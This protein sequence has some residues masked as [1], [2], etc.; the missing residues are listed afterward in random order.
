MLDKIDKIVYAGTR[1]LVA[2]LVAEIPFG[3]LDR[4]T[5]VCIMAARR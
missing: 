5:Q 3:G 4:I 1:R 2:D